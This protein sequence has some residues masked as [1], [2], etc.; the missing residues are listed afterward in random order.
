VRASCLGLPGQLRR[1]GDR[2]GYQARAAAHDVRREGSRLVD[3]AEKQPKR[4]GAALGNP[5]AA[6]LVFGRADRR[7]SGRGCNPRVFCTNSV[8]FRARPRKERDDDDAEEE[9]QTLGRGT[10]LWARSSA[11]EHPTFNRRRES[12]NLSGLTNRSIRGR[13]TVGR[14]I[15]DLAIWVR[16]L[17][18]EPRLTASRVNRRSPEQQRS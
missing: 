9:A 15:L 18:P 8:R 3:P 13:L 10:P 4:S 12:S 11:V 14:E 7:G 16:F 1:S 17:S 5:S 2:R 6:L